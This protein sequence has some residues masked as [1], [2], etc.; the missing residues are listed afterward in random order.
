MEERVE[1]RETYASAEM[2]VVELEQHDILTARG[3]KDIVLP[4][5]PIP[6]H[7]E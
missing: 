3:S 4:D 2:N 1:K 6:V 5:I 7:Y